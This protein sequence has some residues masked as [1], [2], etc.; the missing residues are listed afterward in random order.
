MGITVLQRE[1]DQHCMHAY[2]INRVYLPKF[3][4]NSNAS[5]ESWVSSFLGGRTGTV[6]R[7]RGGTEGKGEVE[8][9]LS[10]L[11]FDEEMAMDDDD[12]GGGGGGD[13]EG[14][15]DMVDDNAAAAEEE[16]DDDGNVVDD[17]AMSISDRLAECA[18]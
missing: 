7:A 11:L 15:D 18:S 14:G 3:H 8:F 16:D 13:T 9:F 5:G 2:F 12:D 4:K 6:T 17:V 1:R 10:E